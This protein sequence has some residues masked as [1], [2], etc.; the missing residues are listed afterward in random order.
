MVLT[1]KHL[2]EVA[3]MGILQ[4]N[5]VYFINLVG[6]DFIILVYFGISLFLGLSIVFI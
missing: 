4:I 5:T 2:P 1:N 6:Y 3:A